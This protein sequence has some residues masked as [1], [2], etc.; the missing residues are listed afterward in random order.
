M[1][2][3]FPFDT[4]CRM[5]SCIPHQVGVKSVGSVFA[6]FRAPTAD[7]DGIEVGPPPAPSGVH[8]DAMDVDT[9]PIVDKN[10]DDSAAVEQAAAG[11]PEGQIP[12]AQE[13]PP[14]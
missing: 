9:P 1:D 13:T 12:T 8:G 11:E 6:T 3:S 5:L 10:V 4:F 2:D 14:L 7:D